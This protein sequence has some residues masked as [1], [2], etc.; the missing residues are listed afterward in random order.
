MR[1]AVSSSVFLFL[2]LAMGLMTPSRSHGSQGF[3][4]SCLG[5]MA[6]FEKPITCMTDKGGV[7]LYLQNKAI[8]IQG[9]QPQSELAIFTMT[10]QKAQHLSPR[11]EKVGYIDESVRFVA[12]G[13][14][15]GKNRTVTLAFECGEDRYGYIG[16]ATGDKDQLLVEMLAECH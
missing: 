12:Q 9:L 2:F 3:M 13:Q 16:T 10:V 6:K 1:D 4:E 8:I 5:G 11:I 15:R 7:R 14:D